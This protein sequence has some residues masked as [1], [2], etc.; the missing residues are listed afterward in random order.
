M[1]RLAQPVLVWVK[2]EKKNKAILL[3]T[4]STFDSWKNTE[5]LLFYSS[6]FRQIVK[7]DGSRKHF[8]LL[9]MIRNTNLKMEVENVKDKNT[10][11][12]NLVIQSI[13]EHQIWACQNCRCLDSAVYTKMLLT[14]WVNIPSYLKT[15]RSG[16]NTGMVIWNSSVHSEANKLSF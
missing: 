1:N 11:K 5:R 15:E 7:T 16:K 4:W 12:Y 6:L 2:M 8:S 3:F 13:F 9:F 14:F 10:T